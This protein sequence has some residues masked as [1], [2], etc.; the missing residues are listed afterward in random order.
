MFQRKKNEVR[1]TLKNYE[2]QIFVFRSVQFSTVCYGDTTW[3]HYT[4]K[5]VKMVSF[6]VSE[7]DFAGHRWA[8]N[9]Q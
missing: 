1:P 4:R 7:H 8:C 6:A 3:I 5:H 9:L 2:C